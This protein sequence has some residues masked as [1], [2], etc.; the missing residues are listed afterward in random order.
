[1]ENGISNVKCPMTNVKWFV[2]EVLRLLQI[3]LYS[4]LGFCSYAIDHP[5]SAAGYKFLQIFERGYLEL[6]VKQCCGFRTDTRYFQKI[7]NRR[8]CFCRDSFPR[9]ESTALK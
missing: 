7:Q 9:V 6:L 4:L 3:F 8:R 1:M 5:Q 2:P